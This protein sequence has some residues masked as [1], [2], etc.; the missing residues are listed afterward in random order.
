MLLPL[1]PNSGE[2]GLLPP[3]SSASGGPRPNAELVIDGGC[4]AMCEREG[5]ERVSPEMDKEDGDGR[6]G[7]GEG[8]GTL[9][10]SSWDR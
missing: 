2:T 5:N 10:V 6:E 1:P 3:R 8:M 9:S 4:A 7:D